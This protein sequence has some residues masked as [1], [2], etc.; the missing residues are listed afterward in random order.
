[1]AGLAAMLMPALA[2]QQIMKLASDK[3]TLPTIGSAF[4]PDGSLWLLQQDAQARL[5]L[6][7]SKD[8]GNSWQPARVLDTGSDTVKTS[9]ESPPRLLFGSGG[10]VIVS[11]AQ[12]LAKKFTAEI[13]LLRS[14]DGG[15]TFAAPV[16]LHQD[17]QVISHSFSNMAFDGK[18]VLHTVWIDSREKVATVAAAA[19]AASS[20][21]AGNANVAYRGVS[22][23]R[24][25]S[26]DGGATFGPDTKLADHSCECCRL[27]LSATPD[28]RVA[29]M[30]RQVLEPNIRDH[31]FAIL[32]ALADFS[33]SATSATPVKPV[34][35]SHDN[36][37][38]D[39]CPHH[40]PGLTMAAGGGYHAVWFGDRAGV[41]QVRYGK[42]DQTGQPVGE[43]QP[44]PDERA[45]HADI[46]SSGGKLVIVWR[47]FDGQGMN[48]KAWVSDD[49]GRHFR[50]RQL[51]RTEGD[52]DYP[53]LLNKNGQIFVIW[54]TT[55]KRHVEAF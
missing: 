9:G 20:G 53:R 33:A 47:S 24:N 26:L 54:N 32:P 52:S 17:R 44:L 30:W 5:T 2:Q 28:G 21:K 36:W 12:P 7:V 6:Q 37:A 48:M 22:L 10:V 27:A 16:T 8:D 19:A 39:G 14:T 42:L 34:R 15:A 25:V 46:M 40:G 4:A 45:E 23:Y 55:G 51:A 50:L 29:A 35:A 31:A 43:V 13:R 49:D 1:M 3:K 38:I 11:Y 18:G 41:A